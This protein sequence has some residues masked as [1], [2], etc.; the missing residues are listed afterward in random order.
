MTDCYSG[1]WSAVSAEDRNEVHKRYLFTCQCKACDQQWTPNSAVATKKSS[2]WL[3]EA[4][5][6]VRKGR[7]GEDLDFHLRLCSRA[8]EE[9]RPPS[10]T[11]VEVEERLHNALLLQQQ[12]EKD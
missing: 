11:L 12:I 4:L 7:G 8:F 1:V 9:V 2:K 10:L 5:D 3:R 6:K